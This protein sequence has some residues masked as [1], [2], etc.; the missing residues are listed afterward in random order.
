ML[1]FLQEIPQEKWTKGDLEAEL[2]A[3]IDREQLGR[4]D[5]LWPMRVALTGK[6]YSAGPFEVAGVLGKEETMRR[7]G[8]AL[9]KLV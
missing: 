6:E 2:M 8:L 5:T 3:W 4:G 9:N 1:N 7:L